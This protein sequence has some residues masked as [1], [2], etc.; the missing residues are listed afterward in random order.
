MVICETLPF[1]SSCVNRALTRI[2]KT[3]A[4]W[5]PIASAGPFQPLCRLNFPVRMSNAGFRLCRVCGELPMSHESVPRLSNAHRSLI[6]GL[7]L[8][9]AAGWG[10]FALSKH[11]SVAMERQFRDQITSLQPIRSQ[12]L[13]EQTKAQALL[14]QMAQLR[15]ELQQFGA[16]SISCLSHAIKAGRVSLLSDPMPK[17]Q[18]SD[19]MMPTTTYPE[20]GP[21]GRSPTRP[22]RA[23]RSL[24]NCQRSS[25]AVSR[26]RPSGLRHKGH[27][28][29]L[30]GP[31]A[32]KH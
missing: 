8:S 26:L 9:A 29:Q 15:G 6:L 4:L 17:A 7:S 16:S 28:N 27:K 22:K 21:S 32:V 12:L 11:A 20:P 1:I 18:S 25:L 5:W 3:P 14:S 2:T 30:R 24:R 19:P 31:S 10:S 23:S 13:T